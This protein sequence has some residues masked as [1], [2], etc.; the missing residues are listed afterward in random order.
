MLMSYFTLT[1]APADKKL[2][3]KQD[4][5]A[6]NLQ[7]YSW[8]LCQV[9]WFLFFLNEVVNLIYF[10]RFFFF[11]FLLNHFYC[12]SITVVPI[13][14]PLPSSAH[15][16]PHS[17]RQ[18]PH[19]CPCLWVIHTCSLYSPQVAN[20]RPM[21]QIQPSTLFYPAKHLVLSSPAP[22][23]YLVAAPSSH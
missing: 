2:S 5:W 10:F 7:H 20:T 15:P 14:P 9:F 21:G 17:H 13:P 11:L 4:C 23:F 6:W 19:C 22:C 18:F 16:T 1:L 8:P 12:Y 3:E